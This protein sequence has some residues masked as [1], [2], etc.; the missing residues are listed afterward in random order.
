MAAAGQRQLADAARKRQPV[1]NRRLATVICSDDFDQR[2][3]GD[4]IEEM[5]A[6]EP[7]RSLKA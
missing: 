2:E 5:Q 7:L 1:R 4:G 6:D 3:F